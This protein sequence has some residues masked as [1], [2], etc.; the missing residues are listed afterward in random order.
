MKIYAI[1][2]W[3]ILEVDGANLNM[4]DSSVAEL[5]QPGE[6]TSYFYKPDWFDT[7]KEAVAAIKAR[8][9]SEVKVLQEKVRF[10]KSLKF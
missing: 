3:R 9:D 5:K 1:K 10:L 8:R 6:L 4:M 7:R 2:E